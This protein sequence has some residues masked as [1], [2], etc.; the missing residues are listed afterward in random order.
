MI[1]PV[2][3]HGLIQ[4]A[5]WP[6]RWKI[7]V[8]CM[9]LNRTSRKQVEKILPKFF[10]KWPSTTE[11]LSAQHDEIVELCR[12]LGFANRRTDVLL[13]MTE[14]FVTHDWVDVRELPGVGEYAARSFEIFCCD[15]LGCE[16]PNDHA[17]AKYFEW[18]K[19]G[20]K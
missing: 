11:F 9:M 3:P 8:V 7:L 19:K 12:P 10:K 16:T 18:V 13:K 6:D 20:R 15:N 2:S 1:P 4:E 5:Y 14:K 17:L